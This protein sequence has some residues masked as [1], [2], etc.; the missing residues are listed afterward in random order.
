MRV[1]IVTHNYLS[2]FGGGAYG[3]RAYINAFAA[4]YDDVSLLYPVQEG[5]AAP[6]EISPRVRMMGVADPVPV[7][8]KAGR[9]LFKGVLHR[10]EKPFRDLLSRERFDIIVFQNSKCSSR[11]IREARA[12]GAR[13]V[14]IH[15]NYEKEY[16]RD[17]TP[18]L[19]RPL[20]LPAVVRTERNAVREADLNL[21]LTPD[22]AHVLE[23][24][25]GDGK[26]GRI[27][28]WGSFEYK[29]AGTWSPCTVSEPVFA[30]T[31]N[32]G[33]M[34][35]LSSLIPWLSDYYPILKSVIPEARLV[36][37]GKN[38]STELKRILSMQGAELV[39]T[40]ADMTEVLRRAKYYVCPVDCGGGIKLRVMDGL[41]QG[42][43]VL[44]HKVSARGYEAF[45][46][47]SL[48]A[49]EDRDSF[50]TALQAL[51]DCPG[52]QETRRQLYLRC[53]SFDA[54]VSR[55]RK[56]LEECQFPLS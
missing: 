55:L 45:Q 24:R 19:L 8:R 49:Y 47:I 38:P 26:K 56:I 15:D 14:V 36:V 1:L 6:T 25:Y 32:L 29:P 9:I 35:T 37:A 42:L 34:Q 11:I 17:N 27:E 5:N 50:R 40:P 18:F 43:P 31:G 46:G 52:N 51:L 53:H 39:D 7:H 4:L 23:R 21:V 48:F 30:I 22:D 2:G 41:R 44:A 10:F 33:A 12:S 3:A 16:T 20:L 13:T 28:R 54:G